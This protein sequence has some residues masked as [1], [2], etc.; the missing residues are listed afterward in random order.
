MVWTSWLLVSY[1]HFR[2]ISKIESIYHSS[3]SLC[4]VILVFY[5]Y[6]LTLLNS[7]WC[8]IK[9]KVFLLNQA[10]VSVLNKILKILDKKNWNI[11]LLFCPSWSCTII[12]CINQFTT[13][14]KKFFNLLEFL[15]EASRCHVHHFQCLMVP[16]ELAAMFQ[17]MVVGIAEIL[18]WL[19]CL[20]VSKS[21]WDL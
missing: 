2:D 20:I 16:V 21:V 6:F 8:S 4:W 9:L 19:L 3:F 17:F 11:F 18:L 1:P 10:V 14:S 7:K 12:C 15:A 13:L 5:I